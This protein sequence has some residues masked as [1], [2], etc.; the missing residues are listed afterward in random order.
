MKDLEEMLSRWLGAGLISQHQQVAIRDFESQRPILEV[1][2]RL[3]LFAQVG[4]GVMLLA[5]VFLFV[6][7]HGDG[8]APWSRFAVVLGVLAAAHGTALAVR[9]NHGALAMTLHGL[10]TAALG[11]GIFLCGQIFNMSGDLPGALLLW[12]IGAFAA[13]LALRDW[14]QS[15]LLALLVPAFLIAKWSDVAPHPIQFVDAMLPAMVL[16]L[17]DFS[18][19]SGPGRKPSEEPFD[20]Q[21]R[22]LN[23]IGALGLAPIAIFMC[24]GATA[25][26]SRLVWID[27]LKGPGLVADVLAFATVLLVPLALTYALGRRGADLVAYLIWAPWTVVTAFLCWGD[28]NSLGVYLAFAT[29]AG[30]YVFYGVRRQRAAMIN[31]GVAGFSFTVLVFYFSNLFDKIG[32]SAGLIGLGLLLVAIGVIGERA[33][34]RLLA[35]LAPTPTGV[36]P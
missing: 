18:Y 1:P 25:T 27:A 32:R 9:P 5:G 2:S 3:P 16:M 14:V 26:D 22:A 23:V 29:G 19:L 17:L 8:L 33:R 15:A 4:G 6:A 12:A 7:A 13:W 30:L 11:A 34:R 31:L 24:A 35:S 10:G 20:A 28:S 36:H 21:E